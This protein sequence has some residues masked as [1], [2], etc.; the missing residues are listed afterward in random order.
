M[1]PPSL[2]ATTLPELIGYA[3]ANPGKLNYASGNAFAHLVTSQFMSITKLDMA[4]VPYKGEAPANIDLVTGRVQLMF[5]TATN[6]VPQ[7]KDGKL[8]AIMTL[9]DARSA[10]LPNV[11]TVVEAGMTGLSL[12]NWFALFAPAGTPKDVVERL[13]RDVNTVLMRRE[14]RERLE[15][16]A[17][18]PKG[19]TPGELAAYLKA[20]ME[21]YGRA[22]HVAGIRPE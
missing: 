21:A 15:K 14:V 19:S 11:P 16:Q 1:R 9:L 5:A 13:S 22:A 10:L 20:Q 6:A 7:I 18:E 4:H 8:R 12:A 3:R 17:F 2:S